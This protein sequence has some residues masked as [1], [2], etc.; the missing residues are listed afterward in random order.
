MKTISISG[1]TGSIGTQTLDEVRKRPREVEVVGLSCNSNIDLLE[2]QIREFRPRFAAVVDKH[3]GEALEKRIQDTDTTLFYG[4]ASEHFAC[5]EPKVDLVVIATVGLDAFNTTR[6]AIKEGRNI[7]PASKEPFVFGSEV[8]W[9]LIEET[10]VGVY[11]IDSEHSAIWQ[12][13]EEKNDGKAQSKVNRGV[14][15]LDTSNIRKVWLGCSGGPFYGMKWDQLKE[16][17]VK[18]AL[19]HPTWNMGGLITVN[20][21]TLYNKGQE[22]SEAKVLF[23][24]YPKQIGVTIDRAS[25]VHAIVEFNDGSRL[26][27]YSK[28][29]MHD[30]IRFALFGER[31]KGHIRPADDVKIVEPDRETFKLLRKAE[32]AMVIGGTMPAVM[33]AAN[34]VAVEAFTKG[35]VGFTEMMELVGKA[36]HNHTV[37]SGVS[38][39]NIRDA[40]IWG[41][42]EVMDMIRIRHDPR[43]GML[44]SEE[45]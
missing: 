18:Q 20:S 9:P 26:M 8:I 24:L 4:I 25:M 6:D 33:V 36:M 19:N 7:A 45:F 14:I 2:K 29:D 35:V 40:Y 27:N 5:V 39:N 11:P 15:S 16:V 28:P 1:S 42:R 31:D 21:A 44:D 41:A 17:T 23:N 32:E 30:P 22:I 13:V 10:G 34:G 3:K 37:K 43:Y 38:S 12:C